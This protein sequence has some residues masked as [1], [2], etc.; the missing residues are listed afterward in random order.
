MSLQQKVSSP[1]CGKVNT[2]DKKLP[3]KNWR[4]QQHWVVRN[5]PLITPYMEMGRAYVISL[6]VC[7]CICDPLCDNSAFDGTKLQYLLSG[8]ETV[9]K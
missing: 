1:R 2:S 6:D 8:L 9:V 4:L 7:V 5:E 3:S